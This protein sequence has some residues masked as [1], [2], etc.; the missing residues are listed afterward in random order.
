VGCVAGKII[1]QSFGVLWK[2]IRPWW[3]EFGTKVKHFVLFL[4]IVNFVF[5]GDG[6][7]GAQRP[8]WRVNEPKA[9]GA[10]S[11]RHAHAAK[12]H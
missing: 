11:P 7:G 6:R 9:T 8:L 4:E 5:Y 12:T 10:R 1:H 2:D 3:P